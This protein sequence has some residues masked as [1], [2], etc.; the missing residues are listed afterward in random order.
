MV[1]VT[2]EDL[3][4]R[5]LILREL[6]A[7]PDAFV[8]GGRLADMLGV[9]RV[10]VWK[11]FEQFREEGFEF[12]AARKRGYRVVKKPVAAHEDW[13]RSLLLGPDFAGVTAQVL[14]S[15]D[16]T[17]SEAERWLSE[18]GNT[19]HFI[20]AHNQTSGRGRQGRNWHSDAGGNLYMSAVFRPNLLPS[21]LQLFTLWVGV[22]IAR[23]LNR[24]FQQEIQIKWP[25]DLWIDGRKCAGML[26]EARIDA[27]RTRD[28]V[29][30]LGL[31]VN[32]LPEASEIEA[33]KLVAAD[34]EPIHVT[35]VAA[36]VIRA[37][38][39]AYHTVGDRKTAE[40]LVAMWPAYDALSGCEL[41]MHEGT[42]LL[43]GI[44]RGIRKDGA[45]S[46]ELP[47]G[48]LRHV[49]TGEVRHVRPGYQGAVSQ[50]R[51]IPD[52]LSYQTYHI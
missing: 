41:G 42:Q 4:P 29:F 6:C 1:A 32:Q 10:T 20:L 26:T 48:R 14:E 8:S 7:R 33:A 25:N 45:L 28:L 37:I 38:L 46:L 3:D 36:V 19:P 21:Q 51:S 40:R 50:E 2:P 22:H 18:G 27:D 16:S 9:S 44:G 15:V 49:H 30:G 52:D 12:E 34:G 35:E 47:D 31:N 39:E 5:I 11:Y 43:N 17:N 23:A 13:L 24:E